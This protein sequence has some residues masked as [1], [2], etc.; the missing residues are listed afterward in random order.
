M[1]D[2]RDNEALL[3][4]GTAPY[5]AK[6]R[7][8][9]PAQA[10]DFLVNKFNLDDAASVLDLGCGTGQLAIPLARRDPTVYAV[11]PSPEMLLEGLRTQDEQSLGSIWWQVGSD[12]SLA[13]LYLP[14]LTLCTMGASFHWM[15]RTAVLHTLDRLIVPSGGIAVLGGAIITWHDDRGDWN[16]TVRAT[17]QEY[18]G[19]ERRAGQGTYNHPEAKHQ[20]ILNNSPFS[21]YEVHTFVEPAEMTVDEIIGLQLSTSYASPRL[22]GDRLHDFC[23]RLADRLHAQSQNGV[24]RFERKFEVIAAL[25]RQA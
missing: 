13:S 10:I 22:L 12:R 20:D 5:Y 8:S 25:R 15:D 2:D 3:F 24:F 6:Y 11:D 21:A 1:K 16:A 17:V 19:S 9:Y 14:R 4:A 7:P 23:A 18:L